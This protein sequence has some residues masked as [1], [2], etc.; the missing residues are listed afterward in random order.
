MNYTEMAGTE[1]SDGEAGRWTVKAEK[2]TEQVEFGGRIKIRVHREWNSL[3]LKIH[4]RMFRISKPLLTYLFI[5]L[6]APKTYRSSQARDQTHTTTATWA[7][8]VTML[9]PSPAVPQG[10]SPK[11]LLS[12]FQES[13]VGVHLFLGQE[14]RDQPELQHLF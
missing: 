11:P 7:A 8:T 1:D 12:P 9:G 5:Y 3:G 2:I 4:I 13:S 6:A 10:N 14:Q